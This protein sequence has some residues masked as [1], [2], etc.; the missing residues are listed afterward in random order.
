MSVHETL[1]PREIHGASL[2]RRCLNCP[3]RAMTREKVVILGCESDPVYQDPVQV[4]SSH[5]RQYVKK[6]EPEVVH[7]ARW[8]R[9]GFRGEGTRN[10]RALPVI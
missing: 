7:R 1:Q 2:G 6:V 10:V 8:W 4:E 5:V 9:Q 3:R